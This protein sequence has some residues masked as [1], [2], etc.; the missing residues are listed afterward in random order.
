MITITEDL[1]ELLNEVPP[2]SEIEVYITENRIRRRA[3]KIT[4]SVGRSIS[5]DQ[6][7]IIDA[8]ID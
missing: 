3:N 7:I 6:C 5:Y 4:I 1:K 2:E 8:R